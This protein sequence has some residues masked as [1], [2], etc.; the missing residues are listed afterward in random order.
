[1]PQE[2]LSTPQTLSNGQSQNPMADVVGGLV[3]SPIGLFNNIKTATTTVVK[4]GA[5]VLHKIVVN[6]TA[7]GTIVVYDN[8]AGSGSTIGTLK[9]S[10]A[11]NTYI[12]DTPFTTGLT[13]VT[14]AASDITVTYR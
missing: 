3:A 8:T 1:M 5:G 14:G 7:A 9:A 4:T 12:Y 11:E 10:V 2:Y 6:T 13:I